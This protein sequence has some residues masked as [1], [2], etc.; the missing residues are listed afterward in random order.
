[1]LRWLRW[2]AYG[3]AVLLLLA[4]GGALAVRLFLSS[5]Q[6]KGLAERQGE[7]LLGR[8][9]SLESLSIGL[10]SAEAAGLA[11]AGAPGEA[12][13]LLKV[14]EIQVL[15]NPAAL[16]YKRVS[17][18]RVSL[19]GVAA[20][21]SRDASGRLSF[22]DI[23]DKLAAPAPGKAQAPQRREGAPAP[24]G[25]EGAP[26]APA[27]PAG[28]KEEGPGFEVVIRAVEMRDVRLSFASAAADGTPAFR[29]A[30]A[31]SSV[32]ARGVRAGAP[33]DLTAE[34]SCTEPG[35]VR[36]SA[37]AYA[38]LGQGLYTGWAEAEPF[39][40]GPFFRLAPAQPSV[41]SLR[42]LLGGK[43]T[44]SFAAG[45][46]IRWEGSLRAKDLAAEVR[47]DPQEGWRA[48][49]LPAA[50]LASKGRF[51]LA[52]M[53]GE[54]ASLEIGLP[55]GKARL[56]EPAK[57]N[58]AGQDRIH[59]RAEVAEAAA[60][61]RWAA[62][63][64]GAP[65]P[66]LS[67][68]G[69]L[70]LVFLASR[71]RRQGENFALRAAAEFD[72]LDLAPLAAWAPAAGG[73]QFLRGALGGRLEV[74]WSGE[75]TIRWKADLRAEDLA[76]QLREK[77]ADSWRPVQIA[78][79]GVRT[80]G[81]VDIAREEAEVA[82][83]EIELPFA[84]GRL[85]EKGGWNLAG[86][87]HL[88][89]RVQVED[90][91]AALGL[92]RGLTG[93]RLRDPGKGGGADVTLALART[94][95]PE[96]RLSV[97]AQGRLDPVDLSIAA[98]LATLPPAVRSP[99]GAAGGE[100]EVAFETG[101]PL[102]WKANLSGQKL[103]AEIRPDPEGPWRRVRLDSLA[104][105]S[106][107]WFD[108]QAGAA[109]LARLEAELP[110]GGLRLGKPARW[111][112]GGRDEAELLLDIGDL[113]AAEV[114]AGSVVDLPVKL[115]KK[116]EVLTARL[117]ASRE[118]ARA[119]AFDWSAEAAF[120]PLEIGPL[121]RLGMESSL[122]LGGAGGEV[123][124]KLGVSYA[125]SGTLRWEADL[126]GEGLWV[127]PREAPKGQAAVTAIG[128]MTLRT[129]GGYHIPQG[130][131]EIASLSLEAPFG[132]VRVPRPSVWNLQGRDEMH[133]AW[134]VSNLAAAVSAAGAVAG[135]P[136]AGV[137]LSGTS[138]GE[139]SLSRKR[140]SPS[141]ISAKGTAEL[142]VRG[143]RLQG[144]PNLEAEVR[145]K[146]EFDG[147]S[148]RLALARALVRDLARPQDPPAVLIESL[149]GAFGEEALLQGRVVSDRMTAKSLILNLYM[150]PENN[151][152]F[153]SLASKSRKEPAEPKAKAAP[154]AG[155]APARKA[156]SPQARP[157]PAKPAAPPKASPAQRPLPAER[158]ATD[159]P[160]I[161]LGRLEI[162]KLD[163]QFRHEVEKGKPPALV[164]RR[165]F[166]L[167]AENIDTRM[168]PG[169]LDTRVRLEAPGQ[170]PAV[171]FDARTNLG[172]TPI[173]AAG[174][175]ALRQYDLKP[176]SPYARLAR[177]AEIERG[178][179]DIDAAFSLKQE[180]LKAEAKGKVFNLQL[181]S[182]GKKHLLTKAQELAEGLALDLLRRKKGELPISVRVQGR[183]DDPSNTIYKLA[184]DSLLAGVF[185]KLLDLGG[186]T[187][188]LGGNVTD[189]LK[190]V[191]QG[192]LP[193]GQAPPQAQPA[194]QAQPQAPAPEEKKPPLKQLERDL[195]KGLKGLFGR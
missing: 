61:A 22:Q 101:R 76:F 21:A 74:S 119:K 193:G 38:D 51:D 84:K 86:R 57:W 131:A 71:E 126:K 25:G 99:G 152:T 127:S 42:G 97:S 166:R 149:A 82:Q 53:S 155:A 27:R 125:A 54:V 91:G 170:P 182:V 40:A 29:A 186:K 69:K 150:D 188:E 83:L 23:L 102:R 3:L 45:G 165:S 63:L 28:A 134:D 103:A 79:A 96:E 162:E 8:R 46:A 44:A 64:L 129:K 93:I 141:V 26:A 75:K 12:A 16:L 17:L 164:D 106:E 120:D 176:L 156:P 80:E 194:P 195:K 192:I 18:L 146:A 11:V 88:K 153:D 132:Q 136:L 2:T 138:R 37:G 72:P 191:I 55:F 104:L 160:E 20:A 123:S 4:A 48:L 154:P 112:V 173:P 158:P 90:S 19:N 175:L 159:L 7:A 189:I 68:A 47:P 128:K 167:T 180:Y 105:R 184:V 31:F 118:R 148:A 171:L 92:V 94:R 107:G 151:T 36:F 32:Q 30:C 24:P 14:A 87:D 187:R 135:G 15:L 185:E 58:L 65:A 143:A 81:R 110:F 142:D 50:S 190:G 169:R 113:S 49:A 6:M 41:R 35:L 43:V 70:S 122:S 77:R 157:A 56:A 67:R 66:A 39:E 117:T 124:G 89:L 108:P 144:R 181:R 5:D 121:V 139:V 73:F 130:A 145:G 95:G 133:L 109:E 115:G 1:M 168:A 98:R 147:K 161:R 178:E 13:P 114:W 52:S 140:G 183:L 34:G 78:R 62:E 174:T 172:V 163:F 137:R 59:L 60:A 85:L 9:V 116:G 177:G 33:L 100:F 111:N 10:F 179:I